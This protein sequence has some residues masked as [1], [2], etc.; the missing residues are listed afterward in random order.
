M[1]ERKKMLR[2]LRE[3]LRVQQKKCVHKKKEWTKKYMLKSWIKLRCLHLVIDQKI[4][5][6]RGYLQPE[7]RSSLFHQKRG[8]LLDQAW[9]EKSS[10]KRQEQRV[11]RETIW[12]RV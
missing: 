9:R 11:G 12:R 10:G 7:T 6:V 5:S 8:H 1:R 3:R 4:F 2:M